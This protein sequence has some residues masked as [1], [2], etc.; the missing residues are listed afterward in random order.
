MERVKMK[1][2][3][4]Y[5]EKLNEIIENKENYHGEELIYAYR[6]LWE[7]KEIFGRQIMFPLQDKNYNRILDA[8]ANIELKIAIRLFNDYEREKRIKRHESRS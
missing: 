2:P 5:I 4:C 1:V 8:L 6:K 7:L 3:D